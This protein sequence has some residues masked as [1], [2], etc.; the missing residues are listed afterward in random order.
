MPGPGKLCKALGPQT[1]VRRPMPQ[2]SMVLNEEYA[3][4]RLGLR[5]ELKLAVVSGGPHG[6][7]I[8]PWDCRCLVRGSAGVFKLWAAE[9][10]VLRSLTLRGSCCD[11]LADSGSRPSECWPC[12]PAPTRVLRAEAETAPHTSDKQVATQQRHSFLCCLVPGLSFQRG[13]ECISAY[14]AFFHKRT[15]EKDRLI[16][17]STN[18]HRF[19]ILLLHKHT[20]RG[21]RSKFQSQS[22]KRSKDTLHNTGDRHHVSP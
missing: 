3:P 12:T 5:R 21:Q 11:S 17:C 13:N 1:R 15:L 10:R 8:C 14:E 4:G 2:G 9:P 16:N 7:T 18:Q 19:D 20:R 6:P 22:P